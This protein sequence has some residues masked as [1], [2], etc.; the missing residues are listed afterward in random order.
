MTLPSP[1]RSPTLGA[2][3]ILSPT[4][5]G[6]GA[7]VTPTTLTNGISA[8]AAAIPNALLPGSPADLSAYGGLLI[9]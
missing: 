7:A 5:V 9:K 4:R 2:P 1:L 3:I 8:A 6:N